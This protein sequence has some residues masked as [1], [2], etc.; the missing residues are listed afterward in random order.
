MKARQWTPR[1]RAARRRRAKRRNYARFLK[2]HRHIGGRPWT[3]K[4]LRLL[5]TK[6]DE[7]VAKR[8][9][10]TRQAVRV[11]RLRAG[12]PR[13]IP[14]GGRREWDDAELGALARMSD[15]EVARHTGRT[16][17]AVRVKRSVRRIPAPSPR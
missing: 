8:I 7:E 16:L 4:E 14:P 5:G 15:V 10:R 11:Q 2:E 17:K 6:A 13:V 1:E 12:L 9:G 3:A